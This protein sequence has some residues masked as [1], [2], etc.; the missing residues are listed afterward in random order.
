MRPQFIEVTTQRVYYSKRKHLV[1]VNEIISI[2]PNENNPKEYF[3][4]EVRCYPGVTSH[5]Q[6]ALSVSSRSFTCLGNYEDIVRL[7]T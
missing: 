2:S 7:L 3:N 4:I 1:N 6:G 5:W